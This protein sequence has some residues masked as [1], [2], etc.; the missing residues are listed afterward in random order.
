MTEARH[1]TLV[2]MPAWNESEAIGNTIAEVLEF[3][4]ACDV[5]VVDDGSRD[6]TARVA[7]AAGAT[8]VQLPFNMGVGGAMR[9]GFKYAKAHGYKQVIQVDADGQHDPRDIKAVLDGLR[10]ADI[11]IGARFADAGNYTVRGPRKWAMNVLA[12]TISRLA[13][14]KLTDVTSGFRAANAK[15]IRQYLDHYPAEYLGDTIDSL[16]VAIRS[17]CTVRQVG[18]SMRERQ[19][20]TPSHDPIKAAI[21]LGRSGMALLFA[22]TRKKS[23][24]STN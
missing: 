19:G 6:D 15:A 21:Y 16:V 7:R 1:D 11:A 13:R 5:L 17:G 12:W 9:T 3:G 22:L 23:T 8:V 18:V 14:T 4:P 2:I 24:P 20:G 10:D